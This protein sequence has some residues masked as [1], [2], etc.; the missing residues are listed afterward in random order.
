MPSKP[1]LNLIGTT[2]AAG[3]YPL[4][5]NADA[6]TLG[7]A[8]GK[9]G[10]L[11]RSID[12][13]DSPDVEAALAALGAALEFPS[14]YGDNLDALHDC[15]TDLTWLDAAG[16]VFLIT[17]GEAL[18]RQAPERFATL[19]EVLRTAA[20]DWRNREVPFWVFVDQ[21]G[22]DLAELRPTA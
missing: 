14:W 4:P 8:A 1:L 21:Q 20:E 13:G 5:P 17:G 3:V 2:K 10:W 15:L 6:A 19:V 22:D 9:A 11:F 16:Y 12:L 7:A 18:R